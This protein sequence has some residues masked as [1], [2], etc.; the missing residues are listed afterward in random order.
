MLLS[1]KARLNV[2]VKPKLPPPPNRCHPRHHVHHCHHDQL[3][4]FSSHT[5]V[6]VLTCFVLCVCVCS[7]AHVCICIAESRRRS[8]SDI[9]IPNSDTA[10]DDKCHQW[11]HMQLTHP[12]THSM[13]V[14][15]VVSTHCSWGADWPFA[16]LPHLDKK[17]KSC[18]KPQHPIVTPF[19]PS[20]QSLSYTRLTNYCSCHL[21]NKSNDQPKPL[22]V[23]HSPLKLCTVV[24][25]QR[26]CIRHYDFCTF[27]CRKKCIVS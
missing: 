24:F 7:C 10:Q 2:W 14:Y 6:N 21:I 5:T 3:E 9:I 26:H 12:S 18:H 8:R 13:T 15:K 23:T 20:F 19:S 1:I 16:N 25:K 22:L 11:S 27:C 17:Y 4:S